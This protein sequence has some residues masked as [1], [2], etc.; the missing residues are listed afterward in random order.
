MQKG[1][2]ESKFKFMA[3]KHSAFG[4]PNQYLNR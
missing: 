4:N 3:G 2:I 1:G